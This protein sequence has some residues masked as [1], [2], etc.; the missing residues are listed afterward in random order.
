M[1]QNKNIDW[2]LG[3]FSAL[4]SGMAKAVVGHEELV[5]ALALAMVSG[6]HVLLEGV[7]GVAK[8]LA[9]R[10]LGRL[11]SLDFSRIQFTP[12]LLPSD[13][14]GTQIYNPQT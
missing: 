11:M 5:E 1:E 8:T 6:Q 4:K 14:V 3:A 2:A 10:T 12:D 13:L 7:P 9:V